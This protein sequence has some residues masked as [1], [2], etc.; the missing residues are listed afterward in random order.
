MDYGRSR[1]Y[2]FYRLSRMAYFSRDLYRLLIRKGATEETA[3]KVIADLTQLSYLDDEAWVASFFRRRF[4]ARDGAQK[5][6]Q[7][8]RQRGVDSA[9]IEEHLPSDSEEAEAIASLLSTRFK[10]RDLSDYNECAK[11]KAAL[12]RKGFSYDAINNALKNKTDG[13]SGCPFDAQEPQFAE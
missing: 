10:N 2:A 7:Q 1:R 11:V 13:G 4:A 6:I 3:E 9:L 8:L 5:I 12:A